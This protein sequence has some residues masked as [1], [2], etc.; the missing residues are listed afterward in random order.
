MWKLGMERDEMD[1]FTVE[2]GARQQLPESYFFWLLA[3]GVVEGGWV[4][5]L[6]SDQYPVKKKT[7]YPVHWFAHCF[8]LPEFR[9]NT[10]VFFFFFCYPIIHIYLLLL[11]ISLGSSIKHTLVY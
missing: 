1:G 4:K 7:H 5:V 8:K 2:A 10:R 6:G 11:N 3:F 9:H